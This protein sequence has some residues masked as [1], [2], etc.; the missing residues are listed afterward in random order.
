MYGATQN[1]KMADIPLMLAESYKHYEYM[2]SSK[3][4]VRIVYYT[5]DNNIQAQVNSSST[6]FDALF[7]PTRGHPQEML[8]SRVKLASKKVL[9]EL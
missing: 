7:A 8:S 3:Y 1:P 6:F 4:Y 9:E 2:I 5:K